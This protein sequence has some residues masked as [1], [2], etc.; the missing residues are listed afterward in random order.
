M[1]AQAPAIFT[2]ER[3]A[4]VAGRPPPT[5]RRL[6]LT[7]YLAVG[8]LTLILVSAVVG[9]VHAPVDPNVQDLLNRSAGF[10]PAH[11][12]GTDNLGRDVLARLVQ[13]ARISL[14]VGFLSTMLGLAAGGLLGLLAGYYRGR[15]EAVIVACMDALLAFPALVLALAVTAFLGHELRILVFVIGFLGIPAF[16]RVTRASTLALAQR[17]FVLAARALG[18]GDLRILALEILPN[19]VAPLVAFGLLAVAVAMLAEGTLAFLGLSVPPP[20]ASWGAMIGEGRAS[21]D[22]DPQLTF[23]PA[24][25]FFLTIFALNLAGDRLR[26]VADVRESRI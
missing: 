1:S 25:V 8:W 26:R 20:A 22:T 21:L 23:I 10:S 7:F 14:T 5:W 4:D 11:P 2:V 13:G 6:G 15:L 12:L 9:A 17:E 16:A 3:I 18:A 24:A 19:L